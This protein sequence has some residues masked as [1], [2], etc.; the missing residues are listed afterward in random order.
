VG[1]IQSYTT[2]HGGRE[3]V[4]LRERSANRVEPNG[5]HTGPGA[6]EN[7]DED[8]VVRLP[9]E[10]LGPR[11]ELVPFAVDD[12]PVDPLGTPPST[13]DFWGEALSDDW[14]VPAAAAAPRRRRITHRVRGVPHARAST[15]AVLLVIGIAVSIGGQAGNRAPSVHAS[16]AGGVPETTTAL[17]GIGL[18]STD[19]V[20]RLHP[21]SSALRSRSVRHRAATTGRTNRPARRRA[22]RPAKPHTRTMTVEPVRYTAPAVT[23]T[24]SSPT[25]TPPVTTPATPP[26][27]AATRSS[28]GSH[29]PATGA[30]GALGPGSSP[31]G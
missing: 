3:S 31:D 2:A 17:A 11:E 8:N 25:T 7:A 20:G 14:S 16:H 15:V 10:W 4:V 18:A 29:Q 9:R 23:T 24:S 27:T 12:E 13:H 21:R 26:A 1:L 5:R 19:S 30:S 28:A 22:T 6:K